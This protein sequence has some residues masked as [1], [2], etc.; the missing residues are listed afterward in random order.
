MLTR[1]LRAPDR[2][3]RIGDT[4]AKRFRIDALIGQGG[5]GA[6]YEARDTALDR[7]VAIKLLLANDQPTTLARFLQEARTLATLRESPH[8]ATIFEV[9]IADE[10]TA[11]IV[12]ERLQGRDLHDELRERGRLPV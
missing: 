11:F 5:F 9:G 7:S 10:T 1:D 6:V 4:F 8:I 2:M 12:M 3:P